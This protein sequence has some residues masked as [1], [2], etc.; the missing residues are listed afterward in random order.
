MFLSVL[1]YQR[2]SGQVYCLKQN[3]FNKLQHICNCINLV[4]VREPEKFMVFSRSLYWQPTSLS[5]PARIK[6]HFKAP[7]YC[8]TAARR[9]LSYVLWFSLYQPPSVIVAWKDMLRSKYLQDIIVKACLT[10]APSLSSF[11]HYISPF[12]LQS[13]TNYQNLKFENFSWTRTPLTYM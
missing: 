9:R 12:L 1:F 3:T 2:E 6:K 4:V 7:I 8:L 5:S 10:L 11:E 13:L